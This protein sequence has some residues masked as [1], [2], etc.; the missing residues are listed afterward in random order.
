VRHSQYGEGTVTGQS[1]ALVTVEFDN[2]N[3][4]KK[5]IYPAAFGQ[6]LSF[7]SAGQ[8]E[9]IEKELK[10]I[11]EREEAKRQEQRDRE[12]ENQK[13]RDKELKAQSEHKR[14]S[15]KAKKPAAAKHSEPEIE[16]ETELDADESDYDDSED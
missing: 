6:F 1:E 12:A 14:G 15:G 7:C 4:T 11:H 3:D 2:G 10:L 16:P 13:R 9:T 8:Q 5:F